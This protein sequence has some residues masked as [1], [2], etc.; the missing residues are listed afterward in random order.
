MITLRGHG[1][2]EELACTT[3]ASRLAG[4]GVSL[5]RVRDV[6]VDTAFPNVEREVL[7]WVRSRQPLRGLIL[8]H[9][10][11]D[12]AGNVQALAALGTPLDATDE[13][14]R[15][16]RTPASLRA[17]RRLTWGTPTPLTV[18][19]PPFVDPSLRRIPTPGHAA[20]HHVVWDDTTGTVFGGDLFIG[21]KVRIAHR[22]EDHRAI[23]DSLRRVAALSPARYFDAH[24]GLLHHPVPLLHAKADWLEETVTIIEQKILQGDSDRAIRRDVLGRE[25]ATGITSRGEY[26]RLAMVQAIRDR[27]T[28][29]PD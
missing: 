1:D 14:M 9:A 6:L 16:L 24:R 28:A 19:P 13:T 8:T 25:D 10:H 12:H 15:A 4:Y 22:E 26:S 5:F 17:Y 29:S 2:V 18:D 3:R 23:I 11:E 21:V 20:D 7:D 27:L